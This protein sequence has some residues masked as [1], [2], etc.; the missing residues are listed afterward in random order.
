MSPVAPAEF[1]EGLWHQ[2]Y[3]KLQLDSLWPKMNV[4]LVTP[5]PPNEVS[6]LFASSQFS[7]PTTMPKF[8]LGPARQARSLLS[9]ALASLPLPFLLSGTILRPWN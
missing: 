7:E 9:H 2:G 3:F 5:F 1:P 4:L 6:E 8:P